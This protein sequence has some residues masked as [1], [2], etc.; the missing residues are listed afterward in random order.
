[1]F[2]LADIPAFLPDLL[3]GAWLTIVVSVLAFVLAL[4]VG[5][6]FAIMRMSRLLPLRDGIRAVL[7][8]PDALAGGSRKSIGT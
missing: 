4:I 1:M 5:L 6:A 3:R 7:T 8:R 2:A